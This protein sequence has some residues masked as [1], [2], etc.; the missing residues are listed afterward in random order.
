MKTTQT[1][2]IEDCEKPQRAR[3]WCVTHYW[4]W[5]QHGDPRKLVKLPP[6]DVCDAPDCE[7]PADS[8]R[9]CGMHRARLTRLGSL[10]LPP[11]RQRRTHSHGYLILRAK[12]HPTANSRG[13]A[14]EH[15]VAL[16]DAIG[17]G[18]HP[19]HW[20]GTE[21]SWDRS[22]PQHRDGLVVD[23]LDEDK[24]NNDP[25]NLV[26]SCSVCNFQ[27]SSRWVKRQRREAS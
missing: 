17:P 25:S 3:G 24:A 23:H 27:R 13:F 11:K 8:G 20:C 5:S 18:A 21:V 10:D 2:T 7:K 19:C 14:Y 15:R 16:Y 6:N 26:P 9:H 22:Y 4:R 1:C 12:G